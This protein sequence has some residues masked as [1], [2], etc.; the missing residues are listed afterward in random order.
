M[1]R[2]KL[3]KWLFLALD[4]VLVAGL[5]AGLYFY[6]KKANKSDEDS[7]SQEELS[8]RYVQTVGYNGQEAPLRRQTTS[9]LLIGTDNYIDDE[10]QLEFEA[11]FNNNL[12]DF[13]VILVFDHADKTVTPFQICRDT[14]CDVPWISLNGIADGTEFEQITFAHTYGTGKEDSCVNTV[15]AVS[16]LLFGVPIDNYLAFTMDAV[17][18]VND[19]VGGVTL[20][21]EDDIPALGE[22]YVRGAA[23]TL[24]GAA[25]LRFVRYRDIELLD[26]NLTRMGHHRL[27]FNAFSQAARA[28]AAGDEDLAVNV[29]KAVEPFLCTD[30]S[31]ENVSDMVKRLEEYELLP[32][33]VAD[34]RYEDGDEF[35]EYYVD[36][37]SLWECVKTVFCA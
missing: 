17:P 37:D 25:A 1:K 34:G 2:S 21:L 16:D 33:V 14:M 19:L 32:T 10:K 4:V 9:V 11:Y 30:L 28:A 7:L 35:A 18:I 26:S 3:K 8:R 6:Q 27:Y 36:K 29:F 24:R 31:V 12:A 23:V 15:T 5:V 13:L 22:E 20:T